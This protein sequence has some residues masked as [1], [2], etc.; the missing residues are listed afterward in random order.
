VP[1]LV[2]FWNFKRSGET[3]V[4]G[5]GR[6]YCLQSRS[7]PLEVLPD[8]D[9]PFGGTALCLR[10]GQWLSIPR[11]ECPE[12]N[13]H[14]PQGHLTL[15][16]WL[17]RGKTRVRQCEFIAGQWNETNRGRQYGLFLNISVWGMEDRVFGHL[18]NCGGPTPGYKY[19]MDGSMGGTPV[20]YDQWSAVAMSYDGVAGTAWLNGQVDPCPGLNP[21]PMAGGLHNSGPRGSDFTVGAVDRSGETGNF[22]CGS[23]AALAVYSRAL[24]PAEM[25]AVCGAGNTRPP[26][27]AQP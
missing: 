18:S 24:T 27:P 1:G 25:V 8:P 10:E 22:F 5:Q 16:A 23:L 21:Y 11:M 12:L 4:A 13:I 15:I 2:A 26:V 3:F 17:K 14:G 7:G 9:A 20:P 6:P 19:C